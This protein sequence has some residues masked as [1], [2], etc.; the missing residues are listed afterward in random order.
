[1]S[2]FEGIGLFIVACIAAIIA[3][4]LAKRKRRSPGK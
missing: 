2:L 3:W 1:M 4:D